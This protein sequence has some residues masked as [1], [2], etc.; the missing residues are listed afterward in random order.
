MYTEKLQPTT[1]RLYN[2]TII[3]YTVKNEQ[4]RYIQKTTCSL[5]AS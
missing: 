2:N 3:H 1:I 5:N 4:Q